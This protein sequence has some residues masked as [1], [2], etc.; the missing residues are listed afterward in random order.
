MRAF[1]LK[2]I[3]LF[4][5]RQHSIS[6]FYGF[7]WDNDGYLGLSCLLPRCARLLEQGGGEVFKVSSR[8]FK[9]KRLR[10][11]S[12]KDLPLH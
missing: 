3:K 6:L 4:V 1:A 9:S 10:G 11:L 2:G 5:N 12:L 8:Y 7:S